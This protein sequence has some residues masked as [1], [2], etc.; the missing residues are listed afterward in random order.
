MAMTGTRTVTANLAPQER[1]PPEALVEKHAPGPVARLP[2]R[3]REAL[4]EV[5][6]WG[7]GAG[8][9]IAFG[10]LP[11]RLRAAPGAGAAYG[12][13]LWL[14]FE[15]GIAPLLGIAPAKKRPVLWRATLAL[16]HAL[17]GLIVAGHL[18]PEPTATEADR[19][20]R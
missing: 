1:T 19:N 3:H 9:G 18:A 13:L 6:H 2:E 12:L 7:Y 10:L 14:A 16:D 15:L 17:Y 8:G 20:V 5:L 4:T 11:A